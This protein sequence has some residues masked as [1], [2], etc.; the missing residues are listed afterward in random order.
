LLPG[1]MTDYNSRVEKR[2][3]NQKYLHRPLRGG[4]DLDAFAWKATWSDVIEHSIFPL[5]LIVAGLVCIL[6]VSER[7]I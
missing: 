1:F 3:A 5:A 7:E 6:S 2:P 4:D